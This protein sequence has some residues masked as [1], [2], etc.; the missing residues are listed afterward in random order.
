MRSQHLTAPVTAC[1][2]Q[3][4]VMLSLGKV[5]SECS[6]QR[7]SGH[8]LCCTAVK[9][10]WNGHCVCRRALTKDVLSKIVLQR[11]THPQYIWKGGFRDE[12]CTKHMKEHPW[13]TPLHYKSNNF[14][15]PT[16]PT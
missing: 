2:L 3:C 9:P 7:G 12:V 13:K 11:Q 5:P 16:H 1:T 4:T 8:F 6:C 14:F 15:L 10:A